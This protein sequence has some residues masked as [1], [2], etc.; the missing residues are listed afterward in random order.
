MYVS[1]FVIGWMLTAHCYIIIL[2]MNTSFDVWWGG[3]S[4]N[5]LTNAEEQRRGQE[6]LWN[7]CAVWW[8][9]QNF[10]IRQYRSIAAIVGKLYATC[11]LRHYHIEQN[12]IV[13][14][15]YHVEYDRLQLYYKLKS[16]ACSPKYHIPQIGL[17]ALIIGM[18][19]P[20]TRQSP[21]KTRTSYGTAL[22]DIRYL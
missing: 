7:F 11:T 1:C 14:R 16:P 22:P 20:N 13:S 19:R 5:S 9:T 4:F 12:R 10:L 3:R 6:E 15:I 21:Y 2:Y 17:N 18:N 8:N